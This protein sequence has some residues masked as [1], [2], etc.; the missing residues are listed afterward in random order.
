MK[1]SRILLIV[2][3]MTLVFIAVFAT[4][5]SV[6]QLINYQGEL[7]DKNTGQPLDGVSVDLTFSF[8]GDET[9][10]TPLYLTVVQE[11]VQV[12]DGMYNVLIGSGTV[13]EGDESTISGVFQNHSE[14][15]MGVEVGD[16]GEMTPRVRISS[17]PYAMSVDM[18]AIEKY[19]NTADADGDGFD[20]QLQG[21]NDCNDAAASV[22]PGAPEVC[23]GI[24]N[25]CAGDAGYGFIDE[26]CSGG[27]SW[28]LVMG[29]ATPGSSSP[30]YTRVHVQG[31][32]AY[33]MDPEGSLDMFLRYF[34]VSDPLSPTQ[35]ASR[36][37]YN[38]NLRDIHVDGTYIYIGDDEFG[39]SYVSPPGGF[40]MQ[41]ATGLP[42]GLA[43][44]IFKLGNYGYVAEDHHTYPK[45][46]V[47]DIST[48]TSPNVLGYNTVDSNGDPKDV[49]V[50]GDYAYMADQ[51]LGLVI[52]DVSNKS[53]PAQVGLYDTPGFPQDVF[54]QGDYAYVADSSY[55][56]QIID[57]SDPA[58]P[59][60]AGS[61]DTPGSAERVFVSGNS[62]YVVDKASSLQIVSVAD[63]AN[64]SLIGS[65]S[66]YVE[67][68][69]VS[70][71]YAYLAVGSSGFRIIKVMDSP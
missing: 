54:V 40:G 64:T 47:L 6:P 41:Y 18:A 46:T 35:G 50:Q 7:M 49:Y 12:T 24:D 20:K 8:Y 10:A 52:F 42:D 55:G 4:G 5:Q 16:D 21:G 69:Y 15:W 9:G 59:T 65:Y 67:D 61:Y 26:N 3:F 14:V 11:N 66:A 22:Y 70:G 34:D 48:P 68:V 32:Y 13:T 28:P 23:D 25:Q 63:P 31:N 62:A 33:I 56:L 29:G 51:I 30:Y 44:G 45:L 36:E 43:L 1:A 39:A 38:G 57:V 71:D 19:F 37:Y 27:P 60:L 2:P 58:S 53:A 17:V